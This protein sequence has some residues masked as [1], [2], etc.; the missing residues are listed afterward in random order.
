MNFFQDVRSKFSLIPALQNTAINGTFPAINGTFPAKASHTVSAKPF[1]LSTIGVQNST[2]VVRT[3]FL[4]W[5]H[6]S[7]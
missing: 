6:F 2:N 4:G 7:R 1:P 5:V 3:I